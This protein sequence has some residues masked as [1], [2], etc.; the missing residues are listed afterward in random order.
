M[1][2][3]KKYYLPEKTAKWVVLAAAKS[4]FKQSAIVEACLTLHLVR[5]AMRKR[6]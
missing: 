3:Q 5:E 4:G 6:A 1:K 2:I